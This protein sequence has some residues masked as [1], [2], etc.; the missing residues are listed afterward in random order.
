MDSH[1]ERARIRSVIERAALLVIWGASWYVLIR[2][3]QTMLL[4]R[5]EVAMGEFWSTLTISVIASIITS[6]LTAVITYRFFLR[7]LIEKTFG[8]HFEKRADLMQADLKPSNQILHEEHGRL[9][10]EIRDEVR[11]AANETQGRVIAVAADVTYLRDAQLK[12]D[13]RR[14]QLVGWR[15]EVQKTIDA[16]LAQ[17]KRVDELS[18]EVDSLRAEN[19]RLS[20]ENRA[21][22]EHAQE[23]SQGNGRQNAPDEDDEPEP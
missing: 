17:Q 16:L 10:Q 20:E 3:L 23:Q 11:T 6:V 18:M 9:S 5:N 12:E 1:G 8:D 4:H 14:E 2:S 7:N 15:L 13:A 19:A 21:L 22:R